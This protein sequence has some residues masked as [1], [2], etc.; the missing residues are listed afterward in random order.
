MKNPPEIPE[1]P[2]KGYRFEGNGRLTRLWPRRTLRNLLK[3]IDSNR[4]YSE[5]N[6]LIQL[7]AKKKPDQKRGDR[8]PRSEWNQTEEEEQM[9]NGLEG[10]IRKFNQV[11][12]E[13]KI[14]F[15]SERNQRREILYPVMFSS[16]TQDWK[17]GGRFYTP[18]GGHQSLSK[19]ERST[20]RFNGHDTVELDFGG[21]H[22][23]MLY[24]LNGNA[25]SIDSDPYGAVLATLGKDPDVVFRE[26]DMIRTDLK[27]MLLA[28][29]NDTS[30]PK[31]AEHR[32][33]WRLSNSWKAVSMI[34]TRNDKQ[35]GE[36]SDDARRECALRGK[37]WNKV[38]LTVELVLKAF[39]TAHK[40]IAHEFSKGNGLILQNYDAT[41]A[42][43]VMVKMMLNE[44]ARPIP[45]LP[46]HDSFITFREYRSELE[47]AM[48]ESY[49][50]V[51][52]KVTNSKGSFEIPIKPS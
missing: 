49:Q 19:E 30:S 25:Y 16:Y 31:Q 48:R 26:F 40:P 43:E 27:K 6:S 23:R 18:K 32:A 39:E 50:T 51:L 45:T 24:H 38:G 21:L 28:L 41:I 36:Q 14:D 5:P 52:E 9:L 13:Y 20:I 33:N 15:H 42:R 1:E 7:R 12:S 2:K 35:D 11:V 3:K 47:C 4:I 29:I 8:I 34:S 10:H 17:Q 22:I 46:I 37:Q 44:Y